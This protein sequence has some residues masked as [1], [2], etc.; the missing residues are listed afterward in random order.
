MFA[1]EM[2]MA[3]LKDAATR[4]LSSALRCHSSSG[5][6]WGIVSLLADIYERTED[7]YAGEEEWPSRKAS[8]RDIV[9]EHCAR[10]MS[11][12]LKCTVFV[13]LVKEF[14]ELAHTLLLWQTRIHRTDDSDTE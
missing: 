8:L 11:A 3:D 1:D 4:N 7:E 9:T 10:N 6:D 2:L 12:L 13:A 14:R 5:A